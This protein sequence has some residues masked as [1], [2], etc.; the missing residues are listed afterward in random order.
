MYSTNVLVAS[1]RAWEKLSN[2]IDGDQATKFE[3]LEEFD[4]FYSVLISKIHVDP[5]NSENS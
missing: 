4:K 2:I 5:K 1:K 3:S